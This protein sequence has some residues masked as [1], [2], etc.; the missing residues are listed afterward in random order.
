M[1]T[2]LIDEDGDSRGQVDHQK[3]K[4]DPFKST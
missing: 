3:E 2:F 1:N 4:E